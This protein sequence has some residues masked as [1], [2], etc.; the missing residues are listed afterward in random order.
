M[1]FWIK[2]DIFAPLRKQ[3]EPIDNQPASS[4]IAIPRSPH[5]SPTHA[6]QIGICVSWFDLAKLGHQCL[7]DKSGRGRH[8]M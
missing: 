5:Q 8:A 3:F 1:S 4:D 7:R 2:I 6:F